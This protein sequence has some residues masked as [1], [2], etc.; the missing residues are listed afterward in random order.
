[1]QNPFSNPG[2]KIKITAMIAFALTAILGII[3]LFAF[4]EWDEAT[5]LLTFVGGTVGGW[6]LALPL[7]AF[8]E[9]VDNIRKIEGN[10]RSTGGK[11]ESSI[12][13]AETDA[14][15]EQLEDLRA[16]GLITEEEFQQALNN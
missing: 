9:M 10:T 7:Y 4:Y 15:R 5:A 16:Q 14:R 8:G 6:L 2:K 12:Q 3:G 13:R 11:T 1:M